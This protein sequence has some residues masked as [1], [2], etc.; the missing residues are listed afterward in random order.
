MPQGS[1]GAEIGVWKAEFSRTLVRSVK[2]AKLHLVDPWVFVSKPEY[3]SAIYGGS[4]AKGQADMDQIYEDVLV[5]MAEPIA[6]GQVEVHRMTSAEAA[7]KF[8]DN[9]LDWVYIDGDH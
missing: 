5:A 1:I 4:V 7:G 2:P 3:S 8:D 6:R 9:S